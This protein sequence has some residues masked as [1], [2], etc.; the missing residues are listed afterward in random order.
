[1]ENDDKPVG[2]ILNRRD[3]LKLFGVGSAATLLAAC[4]P[5]IAETLT[6]NTEII[7]A[8]QE[9]L[10]Q[11]TGVAN[12]PACVVRPELTEGPFF[13]DEKLNRS[14]IREDTSNGAISQGA[15]LDLTFNVTQINGNGCVPLASAQVDIWHCDVEGVYS[16][17][18]NA[19]GKTFLRGH[20]ITD[21]NGVAK[22]IT[23]YPGW[24]RGRTVHIHFKIR[25]DNLEF[26]SQL[27][28]DDA[29][30]DVVYTQEP[31]AQT[32]SRSTLNSQDNIF[33]ESGNL[34]TLQVTPNATGYAATFDIGVQI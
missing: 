29:F 12:I 23:I 27:F 4:A 28:F 24:Y 30:T 21:A 25:Y 18:Q 11:A 8:T 13:V 26:T 10:E 3:V 32:G 2:Q 19:V 34:L 1:M 6:S 9:L 33:G 16:D 7:P 31:Y 14:D 20:Q 17:V 5:D 15:Q 22:F